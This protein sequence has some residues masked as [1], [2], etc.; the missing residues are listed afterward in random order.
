MSAA[1]T[2][3]EQLIA[4]ALAEK[5]AQVPQDP[6]VTFEKMSQ[7]LVHLA[8]ARDVLVSRLQAALK[9]FNSSAQEASGDWSL[10]LRASAEVAMLDFLYRADAVFYLDMITA[11]RQ[12]LRFAVQAEHSGCPDQVAQAAT[13]LATANA[14]ELEQAVLDAR[15]K[16][17]VEFLCQSAV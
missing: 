4:Q 3:R 10:S 14:L 16:A 13:C 11:K 2:A 15:V 6:I 7:D 17:W 8:L 1:G 12:C 9:R 5:H